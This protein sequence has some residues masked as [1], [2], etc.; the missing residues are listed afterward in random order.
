MESSSAPSQAFLTSSPA[1]VVDG[2]NERVLGV[3]MIGADAPEI[4]Q[5]IAV[6]LS[7]AL[8]LVAAISPADA[9]IGGGIRS[10]LGERTGTGQ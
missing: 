3:H 10:I 6:A 4:V 1:V 2:C 7:L 8:P 5:A 9:R